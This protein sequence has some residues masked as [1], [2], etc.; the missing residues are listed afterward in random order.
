MRSA[1]ARKLGS[2]A[3][4]ST[5]TCTRVSALATQASQA[6][7]A[8]LAAAVKTTV[9]LKVAAGAA[10]ALAIAKSTLKTLAWLKFKTAAYTAS[11]PQPG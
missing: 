2:F 7:P 5:G 4:V 11:G 3:A 9:H 6:V 8:G 10:P 1:F